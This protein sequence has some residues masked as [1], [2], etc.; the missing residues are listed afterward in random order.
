MLPDRSCLSP[1]S[2]ELALQVLS[3]ELGQLGPNT[4]EPSLVA[5]ARVDE[6]SDAVGE[7]L[8]GAAAEAGRKGGEEVGGDGEMGGQT[9]GG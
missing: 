7:V 4:L 6:L 8:R 3:N 5:L 2:S 1:V 9:G